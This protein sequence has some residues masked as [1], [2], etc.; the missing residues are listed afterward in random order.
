MKMINRSVQLSG[1]NKCFVRC[2]GCYNFFSNKDYL[3]KDLLH[4]LFELKERTGIPKI[5][6]AGGE[7]LARWDMPYILRNLKKMGYRI[8]LDTVG[9]SLIKDVEIGT[10]KIVNKISAEDIVHSVDIIGI[11]FDG[12]TDYIINH[13]RRNLKVNEII[14]IL[15]ELSLKGANLCIN[16]VVHKNNIDD[17]I[18]IFNLI[19]GY[20]NIKKWQLF[21]FMPIGPGGY[22]NRLKYELSDEDFNSLEKILT[23]FNNTSIEIQLKSRLNRKNKYLLI[24]G[25]GI[26]W[27]PQQNNHDYWLSED[28]N[29][30]RILLGNIAEK[31][32]VNSIL[33]LLVNHE[34]AETT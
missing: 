18:N 6:M 32:A 4:F 2:P 24:D 21:Q 29:N 12:S 22:K 14:R 30:E 33:S 7:P 28:E 8:N 19:K 25:E 15:E 5:T 10:N 13:F 16:T 26:V 34:L 3:T 20:Q 31:D 11:P 1:G 17:I 23:S 9:L 27:V